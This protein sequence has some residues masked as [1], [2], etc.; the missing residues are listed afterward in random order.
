M[1]DTKDNPRG[2]DDSPHRSDAPSEN[3]LPDSPASPAV[4]EGDAPEVNP[5]GNPTGPEQELAPLDPDLEAITREGDPLGQV[6]RFEFN[7]LVQIVQRMR[8][9]AEPP[10]EE[11]QAPVNVDVP[12]VQQQDGTL[13][14]TMGNW[15][16]EPTS[17]AYQW[18]RDGEDVGDGSPEYVLVDGDAGKSFV[19]VVTATNAAGSTTAPP[20]VAVEATDPNAG[21]RRRR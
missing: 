9:P 7:A 15:E 3:P 20:S 1:S 5:I 21:A 12:H 6:T 2:A 17:Y 4:S 18:Q 11:A 16:G 13:T 10:P 8:G 19:C 14:C